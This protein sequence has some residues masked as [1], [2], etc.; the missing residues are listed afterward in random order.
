MRNDN[1]PSLKTRCKRLLAAV[2]VL[3]SL[4]C[5][6]PLS[7]AEG[8]PEKIGGMTVAECRESHVYLNTLDSADTLTT[9]QFKEQEDV[10]WISVKEYVSLLFTD[11]Y[12]PGCVFA[13][14]GDKLVITRHETDVC[15]DLKE[16]TVSCTDW[17]HFIGP[18]AKNALSNGIVEKE[19]FLAIRP[20]VKNESWQTEAH[21]FTVS[22]KDYGMEMV[23]YGEDVLMPFAIAQ[24][25]LAAPAMRA[26]LAYNGNDYFDIVNSIE[27][28]YG[29]E[30]YTL[31]PNPYANMWYSG[32]F[33]DR[34]ELSEAY[35]KY[36]YAALCMLLDITYGHKEEKGIKDFDSFIEQLGLKEALMSTDTK[37]DVEPL[38]HLFTFIFDSGHDG[39]VLTHSIIDSEG[40]IQKADL[41]QSIL[42][43]FGFETLEDLKVIL[44]PLLELI[45]NLFP[46]SGKTDLS[47]K[48]GPDVI[49]LLEQMQR[50]QHLKPLGYGS[51]R[52]D[53]VGDTAVIYFEGFK[54]DLRRTQSYY[55]KL[56]T[57]E[58]TGSSTFS[59]FWH[60]FDKIANDGNVKNVVIDLSSNGGGSAAALVATLGF[61]SPD[62]EVKITYRDLVNG[63]F[64]TEYYHVDTNLDGS[65]DDNDGYGRQ[66]DFYIMTTGSSYSCGNALP[67]FA[68]QNGLAEII[69]EQPGGGDCV[70]GVYLDAYAHVG[71]ISGTK[72]LGNMEGDTFISNENAVVVDHPF[73]VEEGDSIYFHPDKIAEYIGSLERLEK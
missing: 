4:C 1:R 19:E 45:M 20:S 67:Y 30:Q 50:M 66:Y 14:D 41:V 43:I 29:S 58:D 15:L 23:R 37:D 27:S 53:I 44:N 47:D 11:T 42:S 12:H 68:Q 13:W 7:L 51:E 35:A 61:L 48:F 57:K 36:N 72:Q 33:A 17:N 31:A 46:D 21:G 63:E 40:A 8:T 3:V 38:A 52:V 71:R 59:L 26:I 24:A 62:G 5:L 70:V 49:G 60:A 25:V 54:E 65:F 32:S 73:T 16:Q 2:M 28:I 56:P 55:T 6:M 22:L 10:P 34:S 39:N 18:N 64:R 9:W 69:G